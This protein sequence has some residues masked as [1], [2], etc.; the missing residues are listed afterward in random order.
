MGNKIIPQTKSVKVFISFY[1][2]K[3]KM[4][5]FVDFKQ[6]QSSRESGFQSFNGSLS[7]IYSGLQLP[8]TVD[9]NEIIELDR[10][11]STGSLLSL[12]SAQSALNMM[13]PPSVVSRHSNS[14]AGKRFIFVIF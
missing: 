6:H 1:K 7:S 12:M 2:A 4:L 14:Y 11:S 10:Q 5:F 13:A 9:Q 3:I 8:S